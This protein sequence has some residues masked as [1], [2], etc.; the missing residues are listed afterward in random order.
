[1]SDDMKSTIAGIAVN[2]IIA[3]VT[4]SLIIWQTKRTIQA[5]LQAAQP[6]TKPKRTR[7]KVLGRRQRRIIRFI[8]VFQVSFTLI[9]VGSL[10]DTYFGI[11][12]PMPNRWLNAAWWVSTAV[13]HVGTVWFLVVS[14]RD[15][16]RVR[17]SNRPT[18]NKWLKF[19]EAIEQQRRNRSL[20]KKS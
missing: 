15:V 11:R 20:P 17:N 16:I 19:M 2:V 9:L 18:I 12:V 1:M 3:V 10:G 5:T 7:R 6:K 4:W 14:Q 8:R 13:S